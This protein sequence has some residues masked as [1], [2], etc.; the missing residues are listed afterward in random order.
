MSF[1]Q[2]ISAS[3]RDL[4]DEADVSMTPT[5]IADAAL[6]GRARQRT[7]RLVTAMVAVVAVA[8]AMSYRRSS[9]T[10]A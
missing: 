7:G 1:D 10:R 6:R 5:D 4:A 3:F 9:R 2:L 8:A